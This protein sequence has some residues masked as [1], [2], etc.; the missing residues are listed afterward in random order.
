MKYKAEI[1]IFYREKKLFKR[2]NVSKVID[3]THAK[4]VIKDNLPGRKIKILTLKE[5]K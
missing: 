3:K 4:Q 2:V 1:Y 5:M